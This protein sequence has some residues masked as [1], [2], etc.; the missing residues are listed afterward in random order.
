MNTI[1]TECGTDVAVLDFE[2]GEEKFCD[3]CGA[4]F[5][6][7]TKSE[8]RGSYARKLLAHDQV[9]QEKAEREAQKAHVDSLVN[10]LINSGGAHYLDLDAAWRDA[11]EEEVNRIADRELAIWSA[12]DIN[13]YK[14]LQEVP[15]REKFMELEHRSQT[16]LLLREMTQA[17]SNLARTSSG[18][19]NSSTDES[20]AAIKGNTKWSGA[21]AAK[22][23]G[24]DIAENIFG[25]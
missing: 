5:I 13:L 24:E 6:I 17:I 23:L 14:M 15:G 25:E 2:I 20:L 4:T 21:L 7:Q 8:A 3:S 12:Q 9:E 18:F 16:K 19:G 22:T 11:I 1:C 10:Y